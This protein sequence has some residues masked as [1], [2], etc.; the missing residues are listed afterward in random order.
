MAKSTEKPLESTP[1]A[2]LR[3]CSVV[4]EEYNGNK[5]C[6]EAEKYDDLLWIY[7]VLVGKGG[8]KSVKFIHCSGNELKLQLVV[9][10]QYVGTHV[11][12]NI[13]FENPALE[14]IHNELFMEK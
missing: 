13:I 10:F 5:R 12:E 6:I 8:Y 4:V 11:K 1:I 7:N 9:G 14:E 2:P 3:P